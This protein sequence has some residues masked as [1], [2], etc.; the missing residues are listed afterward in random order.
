MDNTP[1]VSI[2]VPNFNHSEFIKKRI[3]SILNQSFQNFEVILLDDC[4]ID[5]SLDVLR[6]YEKNKKVSH[7]IIN[8]KNSGSPF[9][10]W[11]KGID[12][13]RGEYIWIAESDDYC[14]ESFLENLIKLMRSDPSIGIA[15][16]QSLITDKNGKLKGINIDYTA[17]F[18][19]NIW[20]DDF[21][22][23]GI[24]FINNYLSVKA[25]IPN[26]SAVLFKKSLVDATIFDES[27][28]NMTICGDWLFWLK[29][30]KKTKIIFCSDILNFFRTHKA[31]TRNHS[32]LKKKQ[33]RLIE[34]SK[35]RKYLFRTWS[36]KNRNLINDMQ[37]R[38]FNLFKITDVVSKNFYELETVNS[39]NLIFAFNFLKYK[40]LKKINLLDS[41]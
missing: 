7:F 18:E 34:E 4:S 19:P 36:I 24:E 13:A 17:E 41:L 37:F 29:L 26:A 25:V 11:K 22:M 9:K 31:V 23:D 21:L 12:L 6:I 5:K 3:D 1:L 16:S 15:Y 20:K 35:I 40:F 32:T 8:K 38:W 27:I 39:T 30:C 33:Q 2:I 10:Q 28:L 14:D